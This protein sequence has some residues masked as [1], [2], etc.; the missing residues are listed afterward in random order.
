MRRDASGRTRCTKSGDQPGFHIDR[1][2]IA[3]TVHR[4]LN[5]AAVERVDQDLAA[6]GPGGDRFRRHH[7]IDENR[8]D[9]GK[10]ACLDRG[11]VV[12]DP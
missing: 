6:V 9:E 12:H 2:G 7:R 4:R 8:R 10:I 3:A 11:T 5:H 1:I